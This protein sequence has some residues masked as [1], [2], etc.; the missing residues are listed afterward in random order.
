M[1]IIHQ[2]KPGRKYFLIIR[3]LP[4]PRNIRI[5]DTVMLRHPRSQN[6]CTVKI[7]GTHWWD[8]LWVEIPDSF[9]LLNFGVDSKTLKETYESIHLEFRGVERVR[10]MM[11]EEVNN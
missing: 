2:G 11:V 9:S 1:E 6:E 3:P 10:L 5:G 8:W 7:S 4:D